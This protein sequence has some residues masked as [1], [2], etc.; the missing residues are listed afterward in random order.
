[1]IDMNTLVP[2]PVAIQEVIQLHQ[3]ID[4]PNEPIILSV[5]AEQY[6]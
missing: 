5:Y 6:E 1:M 2:D 4:P 3:Q